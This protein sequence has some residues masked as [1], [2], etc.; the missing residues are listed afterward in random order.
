MWTQRENTPGIRNGEDKTL[1]WKLDWLAKE[2]VVK[3]LEGY[4]GL[5]ESPKRNVTLA[6][7]TRMLYALAKSFAFL[8]CV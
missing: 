4:E 5:E 7:V 6:E 3:W 8:G 1:M 2:R